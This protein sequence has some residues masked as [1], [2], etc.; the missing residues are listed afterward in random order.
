[1]ESFSK[2]AQSQ[3]LLSLCCTVPLPM[4]GNTR[5]QKCIK[6]RPTHNLVERTDRYGK[7][8]YGKTDSCYNCTDPHGLS[9]SSPIIQI[10]K[11][12]PKVKT[13]NK[14]RLPLTS[15]S[16]D[17]EFQGHLSF[18]HVT[19]ELYHL[20]WSFQFLWRTGQWNLK[21]IQ[22]CYSVSSPLKAHTSP[23]SF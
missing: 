3:F 19:C 22:Q 18:L 15:F 7:Q 6:G 23:P 16:P 4:L 9:G 5:I 2:E 1:M 8:C 10:R 12:S 21:C 17:W 11:W 14:K 20:C 13:K